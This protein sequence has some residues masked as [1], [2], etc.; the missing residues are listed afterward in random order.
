MR[1]GVLQSGFSWLGQ[2]WTFDNYLKNAHCVPGSLIGPRDTSKTK[3]DILGRYTYVTGTAGP[4]SQSTGSAE[5]G[6]WKSSTCEHGGR[7]QRWTKVQEGRRE[8]EAQGSVSRDPDAPFGRADFL[9]WSGGSRGRGEPPSTALDNSLRNYCLLWPSPQIL[10]FLPPLTHN[11]LQPMQVGN[12]WNSQGR[13]LHSYLSVLPIGFYF[14][15]SS[16][17]F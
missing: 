7:G 1:S 12:H 16:K 4:W 3:L 9:R 6:H 13:S 17:Q 8:Q 15:L 5:D 11:D 2:I 10:Y 14:R